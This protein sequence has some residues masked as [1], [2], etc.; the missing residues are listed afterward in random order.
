MAISTAGGYAMLKKELHRA[1]KLERCAIRQTFKLQ[2]QQIKEHYQEQLRLYLNAK[3]IT[4][5]TPKRSVLEEIGNSITH[6]VGA[7]LSV[8]A[9]LAMLFTADNALEYTAASLYFFG[10]F[11]TCTISCLYHAFPYGSKVKRVFR[12]FDYCCIYLLIGA[13]FAPLLLCYIGGAYGIA[14]FIVQWSIIVL[15]ITLVSVFGPAR[16]RGLHYT[17]Y[18]TLG[19]SALL[20]LPQMIERDIW[21]FLFILLGGVIYS[22][23]IIPFLIKKK[24]AH[25][26]WHFFVL[27]GAAAQW[28][29]IYL[30]LYL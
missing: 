30:F 7:I 19:W 17:L 11:T 23:G 25:F 5:S 27:F 8:L 26:I 18:L 16:V 12:R 3:P 1:Y 22:L 28:V 13:T 2:K 24:S 21:F 15:G 20:F 29:G 9:F 6:G 4:G 10:L 14:F